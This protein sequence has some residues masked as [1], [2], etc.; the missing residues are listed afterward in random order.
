[1]LKETPQLR[2]HPVLLIYKTKQ[3]CQ[4]YFSS[5]FLECA[6][7]SSSQTDLLDTLFPPAHPRRVQW[8]SDLDFEE[9]RSVLLFFLTIVAPFC[10]LIMRY[11]NTN[12]HLNAYTGCF[13][14]REFGIQ[15]VVGKDP[16]KLEK[17]VKAILQKIVLRYYFPQSFTP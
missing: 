1:M 3:T 6:S 12:L 15:S 16:V 2:K 5:H 9:A 10:C 14:I 17:F 13:K 7:H 4:Y 11:L 8:D